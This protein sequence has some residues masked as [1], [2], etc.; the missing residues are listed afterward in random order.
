MIETGSSKGGSMAIHDWTRAPAG[1]FHS[2][3]QPWAVHLC[4]AMNAGRLPRGYYALVER[5]TFGVAPDVVT[6]QGRTPHNNPSERPAAIALAEAPPRTRFVSQ[7]TEEEGYAARANRIAVWGPADEV[8]AIIEIVSPGNKSSRNAMQSFVEES[9]DLLRRGVNLLIIDLFPPTRRDPQGIHQKIWGEVT[10]EDFELPAD[11]RL[12]LAS[13]AAG[14]PVRAFVEPVAVR[15]PLPE[16]PLF[17]DPASYVLVPLEQSYEVTWRACP[18]EFRERITGPA[19]TG[20]A[21][22]GDSPGDSGS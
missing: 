17:L 20:A 2:F 12:T 16:M 18:E 19:S 7:S 3:H 1:F 21:P 22:G 6:L 9:I 10:E 5:T 4:E 13:Y 15:D 14:V 8:I 11:K